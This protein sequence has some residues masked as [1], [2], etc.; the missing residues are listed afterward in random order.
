MYQRGATCRTRGS[1]VVD[2]QLL[3]DWKR[4]REGAGPYPPDAYAFVQEGLRY[5]VENMKHRGD[6]ASPGRHVSGQELC[7]GLRQFARKEYG[8]LAREVLQ[9]W[10]IRGTEDF[11]RIVFAMVEAGLLRKSDEDSLKDFVGIYTF[12][13]AFRGLE[14]SEPVD[15]A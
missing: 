9:H 14:R 7:E 10:R 4:I 8:L 13:D 6:D 2:D 1:D 11:G 15:S 5:T 12:E 3:H